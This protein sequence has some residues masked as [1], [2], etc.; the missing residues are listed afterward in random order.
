MSGNG[1]VAPTRPK[2]KLH[3]PKSHS[4]TA[5]QHT[6]PAKAPLLSSTRVYAFVLRLIGTRTQ[7]RSYRL[8]DR[9]NKKSLVCTWSWLTCKYSAVSVVFWLLKVI[10]FTLWYTECR[11]ILKAN[12][13][14]ALHVH[15][16]TRVK[17][18]SGEPVYPRSLSWAQSKDGRAVMAR[19]RSHP[20][21][22]ATTE[23]LRRLPQCHLIHWLI[24]HKG[25]QWQKSTSRKPRTLLW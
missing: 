13:L 24:G 4:V 11:V 10:D 9:R 5:S 16:L 18:I 3:L 17:R 14:T 15:M 8:S 25:P 6:C 19:D 22:G 20:H 7:H 12:T 21:P 1:H 2:L 23:S